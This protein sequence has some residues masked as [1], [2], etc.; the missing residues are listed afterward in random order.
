MARRVQRIAHRPSHEVRPGSGGTHPVFHPGR[1]HLLPKGGIPTAPR[2]STFVTVSW[3]WTDQANGNIS[4]TFVNGDPNNSHAV[5]LYRNNYIFG[6]AFWPVYLGP[7]DTVSHMLDGSQSIPTLTGN[8]GQPMGIIDYGPGASP[9]YLVHFIFNLASGQTWSTPEGGFTGGI[10]PTAGACY[11]LTS[12]TPGTTA[13]DTIRRGS[14]IGTARPARP[15]AA[16]RQ[17]RPPSSPMPS[18]R[19]RA[20]RRTR[21]DFSDAIGS[22]SCV[23]PSIGFRLEKSTFSK[24]EVDVHASFPS[25]CL[26]EASGFTNASLGFTST[27]ALSA[28]P[29]NP[30]PTITPSI[31]STL[32]QGLSAA[33]IATIAANLPSLNTYG[34]PPVLAT[35]PT[36][37]TDFQTFLYPFTVS[38]PNENAFGALNLHQAAVVTLTVDVPGRLGPTGAG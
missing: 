14:P 4:W 15:I 35:D 11:E 37:D 6:G 22:G 29:P 32:N 12:S 8:G 26:I 23:T 2:V 13:S 1:A 21:S 3:A 31:L 28:N 38:F 34:P 24:D 27:A 19:N 5:V 36:L 10:T 18:H 16:T 25:A 20:R 7:D 30:V 33:Q 9:R 17:I